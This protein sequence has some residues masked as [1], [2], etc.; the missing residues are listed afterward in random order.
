[1]FIVFGELLITGYTLFALNIPSIFPMRSSAILEPELSAPS[2]LVVDAQIGRSFYLKNTD[3]TLPLASLT[4]LLSS[5]VVLENIPLEKEITMTQEVI[6]TEGTAG[7]FRAGERAQARHLLFSALIPSSND[8]L[9]GLASSI[10]VTNFLSLL[11]SKKIEFGLKNTV[12]ADPVGLSPKTR[13]NAW[14]VVKIAKAAFSN[15]L[16]RK[17]LSIPEYEFTSLSGVTHKNISTNKLIFD[18]RVLVAKTGTLEG[19]ENYVALIRP[20]NADR[21]LVLVILGSSNREKDARALL[22]WLDAAYAWK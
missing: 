22:D 19:V 21:D 11:Q 10:G 6:D 16:L 8:A 15:N 2:A 1:M 14:D 7:N 4:K 9:T 3:D 13:G 17:I 5:L 18:P 20:A 12:I